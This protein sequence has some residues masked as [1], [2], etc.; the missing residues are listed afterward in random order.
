M[1]TATADPFDQLDRA[2]ADVRYLSRLIAQATEQAEKGVPCSGGDTWGDVIA[3]LSLSRNRCSE[4]VTE[5]LRKTASELPEAL[6]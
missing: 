6:R 4:R 3:Q 2:L 5:L 1:R